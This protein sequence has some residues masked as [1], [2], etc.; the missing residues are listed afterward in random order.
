MQKYYYK[1]LRKSNNN[2]LHSAIVIEKGVSINYKRN[3]WTYPKIKNS[4]ILVFESLSAAN[5]FRDI[6]SNRNLVVYKCLATNPKV[7]NSLL[8][9]DMDVGRSPVDF[10]RYWKNSIA[11]SSQSPPHGSITANKIKLISEEE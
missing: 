3:T 9:Y 4:K 8:F 2:T 1:V 7:V 5:H 11:Y 6:H 10:M